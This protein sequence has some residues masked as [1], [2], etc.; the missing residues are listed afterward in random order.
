M[1]NESQLSLLPSNFLSSWTIFW[2]LGAC[3]NTHG[4][5][6][7]K[8]TRMPNISF[9]RKQ[10]FSIKIHF[11]LNCMFIHKFF[12]FEMY[13]MK[14]FLW[15]FW[16]I[17]YTPHIRLTVFRNPNADFS[18]YTGIYYEVNGAWAHVYWKN[19]INKII[20]YYRLFL[21]RRS[22]R[23]ISS[24]LEWVRRKSVFLFLFILLTIGSGL[25]N[26]QKKKKTIT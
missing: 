10:H 26:D 22:Q 3:A 1:E 15:F 17:H 9:L 20:G 18:V 8:M 23:H 5:N 13:V 4:S 19:K 2:R 12:L 21:C 11:F 14:Y 7:V 24:Y 6:V 16:V 25:A